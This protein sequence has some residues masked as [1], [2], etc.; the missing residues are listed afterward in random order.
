MKCRRWTFHVK[1]APGST[2]SERVGVCQSGRAARWSRC[3]WR[4]AEE[5]SAITTVRDPAAAVEVHVAD[6]LAGLAVPR[7]SERTTCR[8]SRERRR[9]P[10]PRA[11]GGETRRAVS[12]VESAGRKC[13]FLRE[14][15]ARAGLANVEVVHARAEAWT[16]GSVR[17]TSSRRVRSLRPRSWPSTPRR[18]S[19]RAGSSSPG[20]AAAI[21]TRSTTR[22]AAAEV[23]GLDVEAAVPVAP[24]P[25]ADERHLVVLREGCPDDRRLPPAPGHGAQAAARCARPGPQGTVD[26]P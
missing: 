14:A 16:A 15:A 1:R 25:G 19:W 23:L 2:S 26:D 3:S 6:S 8:R 17:W 18:C 11:R 21:R 7:G 9:V 4:L 5:P 24:R 20:R 22:A 12:L 13:V 10:G